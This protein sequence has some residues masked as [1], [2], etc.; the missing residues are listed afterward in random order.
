MKRY[1]VLSLLFC[2][3]VGGFA[4]SLTDGVYTLSVPY[5]EFTYELPIALWVTLPALV[6][7][8]LSWL[9]LL[10]LS[11][12]FYFEDKR[13]KKDIKAILQQIRARLL[14][15]KVDLDIKTESFKGIASALERSGCT[16]I[17]NSDSSGVNEVDSV[18][19]AL[20]KLDDGEVIELK[21]LGI[22]EDNP[23]YEINQRNRLKQ[24]EKF[25]YEVLKKKEHYTPSLQREAF[26]KIIAQEDIKEIKKHLEDLPTDEKSVSKVVELYIAR[27]LDLTREELKSLLQHSGY[28]AK[29]YVE[30]ARG[31]KAERTPD[32]WIALFE[33]LAEENEKAEEALIYVLLDLEMIDRA[34]ERLANLPE[35][36]MISLRAYL[37]I[38]E[39]GKHY[40]IEAFL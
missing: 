27:K 6:L 30:F 24:D 12:G 32:E 7:V 8:L 9:H 25:A 18:I 3:A 33:Y 20:K 21:P 22:Q 40:P 26:L 5:S 39:C 14:G 28:H 4:Y 17:L 34:R 35:S 23:I 13:Q 15:E 38:K 2:L 29:K 10:A 1:L 11:C 36:D 37:E 31:I 16:P 19:S